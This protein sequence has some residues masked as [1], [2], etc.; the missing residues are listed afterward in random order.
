[1]RLVTYTSSGAGPE[2][3]GELLDHRV[4]DLEAPSMIAW[5]SGEGRSATGVE[6]AIDE[7]TLLAPVPE[8]PAFRDFLTYQ[9]HATRARRHSAAA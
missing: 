6:H 2:R 8:P 4:C 5:L 9:G 7:V 1:M 3:V